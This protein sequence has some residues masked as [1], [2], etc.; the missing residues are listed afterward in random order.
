MSVRPT[1]LQSD[2][3]DYRVTRTVQSSSRFKYEAA[4]NFEIIYQL[5]NVYR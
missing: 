1:G 3:V 2:A 5:F 4:V